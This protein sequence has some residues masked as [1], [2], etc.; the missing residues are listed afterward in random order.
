MEYYKCFPIFLICLNTV[1]VIM[2]YYS[3]KCQ[4][5]KTYEYLRMRLRIFLT[6]LLYSQGAENTFVCAKGVV[7]WKSLRSPALDNLPKIKCNF[8][9]HASNS[10]LKNCNSMN[11]DWYPK[12][13]IN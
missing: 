4:Y 5:L 2:S 11:A 13:R 9:K 12:S 8:V 3:Q 7:T 1:I 6:S 10:C